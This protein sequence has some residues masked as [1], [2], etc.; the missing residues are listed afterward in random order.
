MQN[1]ECKCIATLIAQ[2][3]AINNLITKCSPISVRLALKSRMLA[4]NRA[5]VMLR[6]FH[7]SALMKNKGRAVSSLSPSFAKVLGKIGVVKSSRLTFAEG[8]GMGHLSEASSI[9][10]Q[11]GSVVHA[12]V[13][14][15]WNSDPKDNF[16]P[17]TVDYRS[18]AYAFGRIPLSINRRERHGSD[19]EILVA[20]VIDRA[21]RPLF[22]SGYV[23]EVQ[24]T[25]TA[26]AADGVNDPSI[27]A[28]NATSMALMLSR[29]PWNGP[30]GCVRIGYIKGI[31]TVDPTIE[32]M[33]TSSLDLVYAG[34]SSRPLMIETIANQIDEGTMK[35]ALR[36]AQIAIQDIIDAQ[37]KLLDK[38][39]GKV[40]D[41]GSELEL[42]A[43]KR[44]LLV[45]SQR[46]LEE[47]PVN[48]E[49]GIT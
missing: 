8:G 43:A 33:K 36:V 13:N 26:H 45:K 17:L 44:M 18:R 21:I 39:T 40:L 29:Q 16:L 14:S 23:N 42:A 25:V 31:L 3:R 11:G 38:A 10:S 34:N 7:S 47:I 20:R 4:M 22:P 9:C 32:E 35:E 6:G 46:L 24:V 12:T 2:K 41:K 30:I 28:V 1:A 27:A 48:D 37:L 15:A 49:E 19:E 5:V